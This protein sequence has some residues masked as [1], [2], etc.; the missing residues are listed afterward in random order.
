MCACGVRVGRRLSRT[1]GDPPRFAADAMLGG[2][3]RWLRAL[4]YDT[5]WA[6]PV[7]DDAL[8]RR[9]VDEG[10]VVLTRDVGLAEAW[11]MDASSG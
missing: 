6:S 5:A 1:I 8:V 9:A 3:A 11:W 2:L 10:R 4:G 7:D